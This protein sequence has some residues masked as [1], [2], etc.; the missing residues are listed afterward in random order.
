M[1][2][3]Q[4]SLKIFEYFDSYPDKTDGGG[5][6]GPPP[7]WLLGLSLE[8]NKGLEKSMIKRTKKKRFLNC[9]SNERIKSFF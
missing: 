6:R 1:K 8:Y 7:P 9:A 4:V 5:L 3:H 2:S